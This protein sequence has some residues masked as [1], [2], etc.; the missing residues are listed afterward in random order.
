MWGEYTK[1]CCLW[2]SYCL[3][4]AIAAVLGLIMASQFSYILE[5]FA[6]VMAKM[7]K[8]GTVWIK[9]LLGVGDI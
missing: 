9:A 4:E 8:N 3:T 2:F 1:R 5:G 6:A 7:D